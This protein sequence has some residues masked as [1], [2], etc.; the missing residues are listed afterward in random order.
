[1]KTEVKKIQTAGYNGARTV[2]ILWHPTIGAMAT[3][4]PFPYMGGVGA[5]PL[6]GSANTDQVRLD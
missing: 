4:D 5:K 2:V 6:L 3:M 1:M